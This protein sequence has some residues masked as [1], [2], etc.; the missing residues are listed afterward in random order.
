MLLQAGFGALLYDER[1]SG[2]SGGARR[3]YGWEDAPD[4][5]AAIAYLRGRPE[6]AT[7]KLGIGGCSMGAQI[8][9]QG[10]ARYPELLAVWADGSAVIRYKD[11]P[12][13]SN[14]ALAIAYLSNW[15]IDPML[16]ARLGLPAPPAMIDIIGTITPRPIYLVGGGNPRPYF[17]SESARINRF[18]QFAGSNAR[19]WIIPEATHCDGPLQRPAEY[20]RR[21][22]DFF[23]QALLR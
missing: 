12:A 6:L 18:A 10:A 14:W 9:L 4:V 3:S 2:E 23:D 21:L 11:N 19:V 1:A 7:A 16:S 15:I 13:P 5:G 20:A 8:A 22:V 17:E